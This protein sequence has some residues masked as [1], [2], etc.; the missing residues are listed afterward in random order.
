MLTLSGL[1]FILIEETMCP[2]KLKRHSEGELVTQTQRY[3]QAKV[4]KMDSLNNVTFTIRSDC[5]QNLVL[6]H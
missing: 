2:D 3:L 5:L 4:A 1:N 6:K